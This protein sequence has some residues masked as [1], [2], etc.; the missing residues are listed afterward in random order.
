MKVTLVA[1]V[2]DAVSDIG[3]FLSSIA[4]QTRPPDEVVIVD[5]GSTD[6]TVEVLRQAAGVTLVEEPGANIS[7]GR[8]VGVRAASHDAIAVSDA[9]C[10]LAPDWLERITRPLE[11]GADVSMGVYRPLARTFFE[12]CAAGIS[13][14]EL[15]EIDERSW[16]PSS[17]SVAF[18]REAFEAGGG[19]PEWLELGEDMY[20]DL[21]WRELG[22]DMRLA[23]EAVV[24]RRPR[25]SL[26]A[27][28]RQFAGYAAGDARGGMHARLHLT[29]FGAYA[30]AAAAL[31]SRRRLPVVLVAAG[32]GARA[33]RPVR[34]TWRLLPP[35]ATSRIAAAVAVPAL[36]AATDLAKMTG[37][38]RG[39]VRR[40]SG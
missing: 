2:K 31:A 29:R 26:G 30:A 17:R 34:R 6:G 10:V 40:S 39:F 5:G 9:D 15:D 37:Y 28:W 16:M 22:L 27:Y 25:R 14:K 32:A 18:T 23:R 1:T 11:A 21:R 24:F 33:V 35:R 20:L 19:Y 7:R 12:A 4:A 36:M 3:E 13:I 38:A 8:N